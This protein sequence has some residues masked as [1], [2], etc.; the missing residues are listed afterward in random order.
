MSMNVDK[1]YISIQD[2]A[3]ILNVSYYTVVS[4]I[5]RKQIPPPDIQQKK[6][7]RWHINNIKPFIENPAKWRQ[8]SK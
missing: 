8:H 6:L 2:V 5:R 4:W 1:Q 7:T 3:T